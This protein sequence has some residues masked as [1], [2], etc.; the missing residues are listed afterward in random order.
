MATSRTRERRVLSADEF[1]LVARTRLP[2]LVDHSDAELA[3]LIRIVRERRDRAQGV[4]REQRREMRRKAEPRGT[5]P[6]T[7]N[8]GTAE[9]AATLAAALQRLNKESARRK[10]DHGKGNLTDNARH[11]L[12]LRRAY[13]ASHKPPDPG[14]TAGKGMRNIPNRRAPDLVNPMEVGRVSQFVRDGQARRDNR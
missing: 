10:Q 1:D 6:A 4:A 2:G 3:D 7:D 14:Q 9:K 13:L 12:A 5:R 8:S 11:A